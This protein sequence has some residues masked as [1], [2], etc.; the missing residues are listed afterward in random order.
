MQYFV[1]LF[2]QTFKDGRVMYGK[3]SPDR[4]RSQLLGGPFEAQTYSATAYLEEN[5]WPEEPK[6]LPT[7]YAIVTEVKQ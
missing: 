7:P 5:G 4:K 6:I 3:W 2:K 1:Y